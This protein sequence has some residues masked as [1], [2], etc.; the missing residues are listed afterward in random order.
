M[1]TQAHKLSDAIL[2][3]KGN[4]EIF[5]DRKWGS[6]CDDEWD[7]NEGIV[8]CKQLGFKGLVKVTHNSYYGT[9]SGKL[10]DEKFFE[11][12]QVNK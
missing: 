5:H 3:I 10:M 7:R 9:A 8:A 11:F 12:Y 6:I 4:V 1:F 2:S